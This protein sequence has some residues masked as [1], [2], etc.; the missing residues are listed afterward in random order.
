MAV[1]RAVY[2]PF[3]KKKQYYTDRLGLLTN[4]AEGIV[5]ACER[6]CAAQI[7]R[8]VAVLVGTEL[9]WQWFNTD[10]ALAYVHCLLNTVEV[11]IHDIEQCLVAGANWRRLPK[12]ENRVSA[13]ATHKIAVTFA[14]A[15]LYGSALRTCSGDYKACTLFDVSR[16][17]LMELGRHN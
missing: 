17:D 6:M 10:A 12:L 1:D 4:I 5:E 2:T 7:H 9:I 16:C 14:H 15:L 11:V 13:T 3:F 8:R